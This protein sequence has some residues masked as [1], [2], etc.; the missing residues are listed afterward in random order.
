[1]ALDPQ[2]DAG[3]GATLLYE[4]PHA[5]G[6]LSGIPFHV[7]ASPPVSEP[8]G[9]SAGGLRKGKE[10]DPGRQMG[11]RGRDVGGSRLQPDRR[12]VACAAGA[13][14]QALLPGRIRRG[15]PR[16]LASRCVRVLCRAPADSPQK[17]RG[18]V[19]DLQNQL[20]RHQQ[21]ALR[22]LFVEGY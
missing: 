6:A 22:H 20:E 10:S 3:E 13:L 17:R 9:G 4:Q 19:R 14:R 1:M 11:S 16:A 21:N 12:R 15:E 18:L 5:D 7:L 8:Q 2:A